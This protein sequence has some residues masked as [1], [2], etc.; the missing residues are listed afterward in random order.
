MN[1]FIEH[2]R[3][4]ESWKLNTVIVGY[5]WVR[6]NIE[7]YKYKRVEGTTTTHT[8]YFLLH[9]GFI[10]R[11]NNLPINLHSFIQLSIRYMSGVWSMLFHLY[12]PER[13]PTK[14]GAAPVTLTFFR[15]APSQEN[16]SNP[17][18]PPPSLS[19]H[20]HTHASW[21][22]PTWTRTRMSTGW[23]RAASGPFT[24]S[25]SARSTWPR[26][27]SCRLRTS[28][29]SST[30]CTAS[31]VLHGCALRVVLCALLFGLERVCVCVVLEC[32]CVC[33]FET[34]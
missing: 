29:R 18:P 34:D 20:A 7:N 25:C 11:L 26:P 5:K 33:V 15:Q 14:A 31:Y 22:L 23:T 27:C 12:V 1:G 8:L 3:K 9:F 13:I 10:M 2:A 19:T 21:A 17:P 32:Q 24:G 4:S 30:S 16:N 6:K 28:G